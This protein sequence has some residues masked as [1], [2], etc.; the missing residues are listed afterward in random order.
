MA[1]GN[2]RSEVYS[3]NLVM[4]I[5]IGLI[6]LA[7]LLLTGGC[8]VEDGHHYR[9]GYIGVYGEEYPHRYY[10]EYHHRPYDR[11]HYWDRRY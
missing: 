3:E 11:D 10:G 5:I 6:G 7:T 8:I 9:G 2:A 1:A 4:K